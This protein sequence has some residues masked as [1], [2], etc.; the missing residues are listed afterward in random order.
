MESAEYYLTSWQN[1]APGKDWREQHQEF[2]RKA[3]EIE[4]KLREEEANTIRYYSV[5]IRYFPPL[6]TSWH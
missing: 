6:T 5:Q 3:V 1:P 4:R 2:M